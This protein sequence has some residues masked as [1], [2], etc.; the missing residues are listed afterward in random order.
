MTGRYERA[1]ATWLGAGATDLWC[2]VAD[3]SA[4]GATPQDVGEVVRTYDRSAYLELPP[5]A[6][7]G[8]GPPLVL[9]CAAPFDGPLVTRLRPGSG[10]P[11]R[12]LDL[13]DG[14]RCRLRSVARAAPGTARLVVSVGETLEVVVDTDTA[15]GPTATTPLPPMAP[16]GTIRARSTRLLR[17]LVDH[18]AEDGL[19]WAP[20]LLAATRGCPPTGELDRFVEAWT[21]LV[22]PDG[23]ERLPDGAVAVV[24][25]G[26]GATP[27]GDDIVAGV[28]F[29]LYQTTTGAQRRRVRGLGDRVVRAAAGRTTTVSRALLAQATRGRASESARQTLQ[30]LVAPAATEPGARTDAAA[31]LVE[32]GHTSGADLLVGILTAVALV[33]PALQ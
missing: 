10:R 9:L 23:P 33:R 2:G 32:T 29:G 4:T 11:F 30:A 27:S 20:D 21:A 8:P 22:S 5:A 31:A 12:S 14:D 7:V 28:L 24:G 16:A 17:W 15:D 1:R 3:A 26:P 25:R 18:D 13:A 6:S 19:D